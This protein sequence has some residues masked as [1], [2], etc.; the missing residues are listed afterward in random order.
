MNDPR[1]TAALRVCTTKELETWTL[2]EQGLSLRTLA[3]ALDVSVSTVRTRLHNAD[4]KIEL[5]LRRNAA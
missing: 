4:R 3:L 5:E 1:R 2:R